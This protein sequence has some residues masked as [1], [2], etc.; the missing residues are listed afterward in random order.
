MV[1]QWFRCCDRLIAECHAS[2]ADADVDHKSVVQV[3]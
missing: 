1:N 2:C 3:L